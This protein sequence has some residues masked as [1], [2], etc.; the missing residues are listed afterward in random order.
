LQ[1]D[2]SI[3][4]LEIVVSHIRKEERERELENAV[5]RTARSCGYVCT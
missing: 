5:I 2:A 4:G 1:I 3:K